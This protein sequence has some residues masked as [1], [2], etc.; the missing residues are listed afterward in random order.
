MISRWVRV[1]YQDDVEA[2]FFSYAGKGINVTFI[3]MDGYSDFKRNLVKVTDYFWM[4]VKKEVLKCLAEESPPE[5][6]LTAR[7]LASHRA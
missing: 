4:S 5:Q 3:A 7:C 6:A 1:S 2:S